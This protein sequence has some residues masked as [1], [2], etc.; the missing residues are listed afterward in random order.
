MVIN[1]NIYLLRHGETDWN[2][3]GLLQGHTDIPLNE[4]GRAQMRDAANVLAG[5][6]V[7][8]DMI[9]S[10]PL[11]RA[12]ESAEIVADRLAYRRE[13]IVVEEMLIERGFGAGEGLTAQERLR[14]YP[15]NN[16]P[17]MESQKDLVERARLAFE[18][19][20]TTYAAAE[21]ILLVAH[22]AI[23]SAVL[24]AV[25][26]EQTIYGGR[27]AAVTQGSIYRIRYADGMAGVAKYDGEKA[28]FLEV[29][30]ETIGRSMKIYM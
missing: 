23:L 16:Y 4:N 20:V 3:S 6:G 25:T 24:A 21:N 28:D 19:I 27:A 22:G 8:L 7:R 12:R 29:D 1:M 11:S 26:D 10:S 14:K 30:A 9:L 18:K 13:N 5:A 2:K 15:D 17:A